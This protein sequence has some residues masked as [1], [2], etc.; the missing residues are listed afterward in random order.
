L[1]ARGLAAGTLLALLAPSIGLAQTATP[2]AAATPP[3]Q[4]R[5]IGVETGEP[6]KNS[7]GMEGGGG[8]TCRPLFSREAR[9]LGPLLGDP[10]KDSVGY[11][12]VG[13]EDCPASPRQ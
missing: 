6:E 9:A 13:Q 8:P 1:L 2:S 12:I 4:V 3:A 5:L 7:Y 11:E 10:E